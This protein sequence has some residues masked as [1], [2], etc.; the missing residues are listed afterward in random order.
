MKTAI[1]RI[2]GIFC[3]FSFIISP[4]PTRPSRLMPRWLHLDYTAMFSY[5]ELKLVD[6]LLSRSALARADCFLDFLKRK[7]ATSAEWL[8][9]IFLHYPRSG[10][11]SD[12]RDDAII[13]LASNKEND[14]DHRSRARN[15]N[16]RW[17]IIL[18]KFPAL[19][20]ARKFS[21]VSGLSA[22]L[23]PYGSTKWLLVIISPDTFGR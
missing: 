23:Y 6:P 4:R 8:M 18:T 1:L 20:L 14:F 12:S 10:S 17:Y 5:A 22:V 15:E 19:H 13:G 11:C 3:M 7:K 9:L 16:T 21:S 2:E